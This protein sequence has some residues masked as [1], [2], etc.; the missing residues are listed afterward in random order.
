MDM[1]SIVIARSHIT[2]AL[3]NCRLNDLLHVV[4]M[5]STFSS[6]WY[7]WYH[8][9]SFWNQLFVRTNATGSLNSDN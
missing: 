6:F 4:L 9:V 3:A 1:H 5:I 7:D 8:L 2:I